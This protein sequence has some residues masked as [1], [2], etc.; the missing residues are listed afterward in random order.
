M[1]L[2]IKIFLQ[3]IGESHAPVVAR[4]HMGSSY[5]S[6]F[7]FCRVVA[8]EETIASKIEEK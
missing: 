2:K 5:C 1:V 6:G 3:F 7:M 8:K 4:Y